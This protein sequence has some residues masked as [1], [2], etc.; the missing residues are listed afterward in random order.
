[1]GNLKL[2]LA[3]NSEYN[4]EEIENLIGVK[5][6]AKL[7]YDFFIGNACEQNDLVFLEN[8]TSNR[9]KIELRDFIKTI[10]KDDVFIF[11]FIGH[12]YLTS[13]DKDRLLMATS[14]TI[15]DNITANIGL[16]FTILTDFIQEHSIKKSVIIIDSCHSGVIMHSN[17]CASVLIASTSATESAFTTKISE[18]E[19][20][21]FSYYFG[22][23][24]SEN[25]TNVGELRSIKAIYEKAQSYIRGN[26]KF[27]NEMNCHI[28]SLDGLAD[29]NLIPSSNGKNLSPETEIPIVDWRIT[30][31]CSND[32]NFCYASNEGIKNDLSTNMQDIDLI[33]EQINKLGCRTICITGGEPTL[34]ENIVYILREL[35]M[36]NFSIYLSTN[37]EKYLTYNKTIE[38]LLD[39]LSLPLDGYNDESNTCNGRNSGSFTQV[40]EILKYYKQN[41]NRK[42]KPKIKIS[43]LLSK[44]NCTVDHITKISRFLDD[45]SSVVDIWKIYEFIPESRGLINRYEYE[46]DEEQIT[47]IEDELKK[48]SLKSDYKIELVKRPERNSAYFIVQPNADIII[49]ME[50]EKDQVNEVIIGNILTDDIEIIKKKWL[51]KVDY[52][53]CIELQRVRNFNKSIILPRLHKDILVQLSHSNTL[54]SIAQ[55]HSGLIAKHSF[56]KKSEIKDVLKYL[57]DIRI[58][59]KIIPIINLK[60]LNLNTYLVTLKIKKNGYLSKK[61]IADVLCYNKQV[62]WVSEFSSGDFRVAI[63][64][65]D[66][67][68]AE[69]VI[70]RIHELLSGDLIDNDIQMLD[71][72]YALGEANIFSATIKENNISHMTNQLDTLTLDLEQFG[73]IKKITTIDYLIQESFSEREIDIIRSLFDEQIFK[74]IHPLLDTKLIGY[75][76]YL[77][78]VKLNNDSKKTFNTNDFVE[79]LYSNFGSVLTHINVYSENFNS[80]HIRM[81]YIRMDF[82]IHVQSKAEMESIKRQIKKKFNKI[83]L[84]EKKIIQEHKFEFTTKIVL[85]ELRKYVIE[86]YNYEENIDSCQS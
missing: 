79:Y 34:C 29:E 49:P 43:T 66:N 80:T 11:Y 2:F 75:E 9:L 64:A 31:K 48:V 23:A 82:E 65:Q 16:P 62:G 41:R 32:C 81:N 76:W 7:I 25:S 35:H 18:Q 83:Y 39:K 54:P 19:H 51:N 69:N 38:D 21:V 40:V 67:E 63:F 4:D 10:Q 22:K 85:D 77:I 50:A 44:N 14:D 37:G 33:I 59:K 28:L 73:I 8:A 53:K 1:M 71:V 30:S 24:L 61:H 55:I 5:N 26:D 47:D 15:K 57:F 36:K 3:A 27:R 70:V 84:T 42:S 56:I 17:D 60:L 45:Y 78:S 72:S 52:D 86:E 68:E 74:K 13:A 58:I 12:G 46:I 20:A 6:S